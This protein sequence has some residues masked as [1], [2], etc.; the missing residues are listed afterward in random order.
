MEASGGDR[1]RSLSA[2]LPQM[3]GGFIGVYGA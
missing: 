1:R 3:G 2:S